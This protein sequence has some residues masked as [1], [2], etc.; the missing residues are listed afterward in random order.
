MG[1]GIK[2]KSS[3]SILYMFIVLLSNEGEASKEENDLSK[4]NESE[5][6]LNVILSLLYLVNLPSHIFFHNFHCF[7]KLATTL[8]TTIKLTT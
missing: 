7:V 2:K 1:S 8:S 4:P 3:Y 5:G 6:N